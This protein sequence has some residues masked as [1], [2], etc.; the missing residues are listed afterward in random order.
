MLNKIADINNK[1]SPFLAG[2]L[3]VSW[4]VISMYPSID[5]KAGLAACKEPLDSREKLS[6]S[7][8]CLL[9]NLSVKKL[10]KLHL[11]VIIQLLTINTTVKIE[12]QQW[13]HT[14]L[15]AMLI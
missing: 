9:E 12:V 5:N 13:G 15:V 2:A 1:F 8:E 4:D 6:P 3:L 7:T 10:S 11:N 14:M